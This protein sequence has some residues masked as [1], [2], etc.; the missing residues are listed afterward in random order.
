MGTGMEWPHPT[1]GVESGVA[2]RSPR[3]VR[4]LDVVIALAGL[5]ALALW[6]A[7][8][9]APRSV[10]A[11]MPAAV[12]SDGGHAFVFSP[13]FAPRWPYAAPSHPDDALAP[14]DA[15][16]L[17]DGRP[18]GALDPAHA[19]IRE[20]GGGLFNLW[21]GS[22]W[23]SPSDGTD[24]R[25]NGRSYRLIVRDR[26]APSAAALLRWSLAAFAAL[27]VLRLLAAAAGLARRADPILAPVRRLLGR[28]P[29]G[30]QGAFCLACA[31]TLGS[32]AVGTL[33]RPMP[34]NFELDSFSYVQTGLLWDAGR[35]V[36]GSSTRDVGYPAVTALALALGSLGRLPAIQL[37]LV[38][39]GLAC[40]LH[41]GCRAALLSALRLAA[42]ARVP[43][44]LSG[45]VGCGLAVLY[46]SLLFGHD[47]FV[48]DIYSAMGEAPHIMPTAAALALLVSSWTA[49]GRE[50]RLVCAVAAAGAA[51]LST[52]VKP[53]TAVALGLCIGSLALVALTNLRALRSPAVLSAFLATALAAGVVGWADRVVTPRD[54]DFGPKTIMCNHLDVVVQGFD[55]STPGRARVASLMR[56][57][58]DSPDKWPLLGLD[59]DACVYNGEMTDAV[60]AVARDEGLSASAWQ[61]REFGRAVAAHPLAY[62][63]DVLNQLGYY[64]GH[65]VVDID[66]RNRSVMPADVWDRLAPF[67]ARV[68][69]SHDD[70]VGEVVNWVSDAHPWL[71][72]LAKAV[73]GDVG[74]T[75]APCTLGGT[76]LALFVL[77]ASPRGTDV[78]LEIVLLVT[79]AFTAAFVMTTA[80]SHSF[81]IAR[82]LTDLL[83][84]SLLWGLLGAAYLAHAAA[85]CAA[86]VGRRRVAAPSDSSFRHMPRRG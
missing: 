80:L 68:G 76:V 58:L 28:S 14:G 24:P 63:R 18:I 53:H 23:F 83:P 32:F 6:V 17:E 13:G 1:S 20:R 47:L 49:R 65:P 34:L 30:L 67:R 52:M 12:A 26:L 48:I 10:A 62:A 66:H 16:V 15:A 27:L 8:A 33:A 25:T 46:L 71:S 50:R 78:R 85:L 38:M 73:L 36:T 35:D 37:A 51:Y 75:F 55:A 19:H 74:A 86:L 44:V 72:A 11:V 9:R 77:L 21:N 79:A 4:P 84:F 45:A 69:L 70:F 60:K 57:V 7:G 5:V 56:A 3:W 29:I 31:V 2:G 41:V 42:A 81:D 39:L 61:S 64:F 40:L 59:G 82:Y 43:T 22:L 54:A